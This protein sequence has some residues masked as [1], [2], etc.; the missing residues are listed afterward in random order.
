[1]NKRARFAAVVTFAAAFA[2]IYAN[3]A[4]SHQ[5]SPGQTAQ[6][7][8]PPADLL[9]RNG[10]IVTVDDRLPEAQALAARDG[11]IVFV[12]AAA[13]AQRFVGP[14][15]QVIDLNGQ[16][17]MPGF[18]EGHGHFTEIG[19]DRVDLDFSRTK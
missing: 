5:A 12:G 6:T 14:S 1:M 16:F 7:Q 18:I 4:F 15:T 8:T 10:R 9:L 17:A 3:R 2:A 13:D 19:A 11:K